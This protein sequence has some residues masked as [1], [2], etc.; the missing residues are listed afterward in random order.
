MH[1][2]G[3]LTLVIAAAIAAAAPASPAQA[4]VG[5]CVSQPDDGY[6]TTGPD[7]TQTTAFTH[8]TI[9]PTSARPDPVVTVISPT[10]AAGPHPVIF[11][12]HAYGATQAIQ[13]MGLFQVLA[14]HG[15]VV[16]H[17]TY[18]TP[19]ISPF[20]SLLRY[21]Q[22]WA[23]FDKAVHDYGESL[24]MDLTRVGFAGHSFGGGAALSMY[25]RGVLE[26]GWGSN[27]S[28]IATFAPFRVDDFTAEDAAAVPRTTKLLVEV[29]DHD[30]V[31]D[32][33]GAIERVWKPLAG[34][35]RSVDRD[36]VLVHAA[37]NG[38]CSLP[39]NHAVPLEIA[40]AG[41]NAVLDDY[42]VWAVR[43]KMQ[44][45][46]ACTFEHEQHGCEV[47]IGEADPLQAEMGNWLADGTPVGSLESLREPYPTNCG[48]GEPCQFPDPSNPYH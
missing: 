4:A 34:S 21:D 12:S 48:P 13:Y 15:Y 20:D 32:H 46:A 27:G 14:S 5:D 38:A 40:L 31:N 35:I 30:E 9:P 44:G 19:P 42:D 17:S 47:S 39:D 11:W 2:S 36:Y 16:I 1:W 22:L 29:Y 37:Q 7:A 28:F 41:G 25:K 24:D 43:R 23:G 3:G 6:G 18:Q 8:P 10:D 33:R 26:R 45:L